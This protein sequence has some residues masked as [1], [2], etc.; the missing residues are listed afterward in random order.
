M[1][2]HIDRLFVGLMILGF[3]CVAVLLIGAGL[4]W[5]LH[6]SILIPITAGVLVAAYYVGK[7]TLK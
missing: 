4:V 6:N 2:E 5:L 3:S 7:R 1:G